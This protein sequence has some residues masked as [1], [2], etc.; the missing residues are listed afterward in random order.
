MY[1]LIWNTKAF[2][3]SEKLDKEFYDQLL[4]EAKEVKNI[5]LLSMIKLSGLRV[6]LN[7]EAKEEYK[8]TY[9][10]K[11]NSWQKG[12]QF[13]ELAL[14]HS[15]VRSA[16]IIAWDD[17]D[18]AVLDKQPFNKILKNYE[19]EAMERSIRDLQR[20]IIFKNFHRKAKLMD[21]T[22]K[23]HKIKLHKGQKLFTEDSP[24]DSLYVVKDGELDILKTVYIDFSTYQH[25][26]YH[27][28]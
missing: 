26:K 25:S 11:I 1:E 8:I 9:Q 7:D 28:L 24:F 6:K 22:Q 15:Q 16:T 27:Y 19:S 23:I 17:T 18:W 4:K 2:K 20:F 12:Q 3:E 13:G 21:I 14:M 10:V 5:K